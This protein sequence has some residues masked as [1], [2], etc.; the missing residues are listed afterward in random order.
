MAPFQNMLIFKS[1]LRDIFA[2][3][4]DV[5]GTNRTHSAKPRGMDI[6]VALEHKAMDKNLIPTKLWLQKCMQLYAISQVH[7]GKNFHSDFL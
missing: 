4:P 7:H 1:I 2:G 5:P 3:L 6:E